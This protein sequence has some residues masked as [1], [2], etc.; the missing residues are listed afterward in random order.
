MRGTGIDVRAGGQGLGRGG[1]TREES[2]RTADAVHRSDLCLGFESTSG[3]KNDP[4]DDMEAVMENVEERA[5]ICTRLELLFGHAGRVKVVG[6]DGAQGVKI[7]VD[8][9]PEGLLGFRRGRL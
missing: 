8:F 6:N 9:L 2:A 3:G 1:L 5:S 4:T 7:G